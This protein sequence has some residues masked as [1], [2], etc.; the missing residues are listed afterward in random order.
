MER[1][2]KESEE[3]GVR[4]QIKKSGFEENHTET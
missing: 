2:R 4:V 1:K 3:G